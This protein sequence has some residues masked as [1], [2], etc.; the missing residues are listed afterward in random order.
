MASRR[1][2]STE[3]LKA[4]LAMKA[5]SIS[6]TI[7]ARRREGYTITVKTMNTRQE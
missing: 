6:A 1:R 2:A 3:D 5:I 7:R 4:N